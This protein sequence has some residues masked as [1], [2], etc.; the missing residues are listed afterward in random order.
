MMC[1]CKRLVDWQV[2][3]AAMRRPDKPA[4]TKHQ[5]PAALPFTTQQAER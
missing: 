5:S 2:A 4:F 3:I 1:I